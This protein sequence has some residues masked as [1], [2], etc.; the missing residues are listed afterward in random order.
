MKKFTSLLIGCSLALSGVAFAQQP[1]DQGGPDNKKGKKQKQEA[2]AK[3]DQRSGDNAGSKKG[4]AG[5]NQQADAQAGQKSG[6]GNANRGQNRDAGGGAQASTD[7]SAAT[8]PR[9]TAEQTQQA[10]RGGKKQGGKAKDA[11][12][13]PAAGTEQSGAQANTGGGGKKK[14]DPQVV[15][16]VTKQHSS[17]RAQP[18]PDKVKTV[19]FQQNYRI[20]GA[21]RWQG[22]QYEVYRSYRPER[23]DRGWYHSHYPRV[24]LIAGGYYY[25]NNG[26]WF[27]AWGYSPQAEYYAYDA[28]IYV[29]QGAEPP[30][31][32]IANVQAVLQKMGYYRGEVDGLLGPLTREALTAYQ[33]SQ[34]LTRTAVIDQP[35]LS[36]LGMS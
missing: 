5:A 29:G 16:Q 21:D 34:G 19:M 33:G 25:W 20:Q 6:K 23:H 24:E 7:A 30:D 14:P 2:K 15:Q 1:D 27:P 17:F 9:T 4:D 13:A 12:A 31:R 26:Y 36:S 8:V 35:T 28:P 32:V 10:D 11:A 18:R 3:S 22:P